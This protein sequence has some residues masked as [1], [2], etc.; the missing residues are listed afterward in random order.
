MNELQKKWLK[1][2]MTTATV[3]ADCVQSERVKLPEGSLKDKIPASS[4]G[5]NQGR[6]HEGGGIWLSLEGISEGGQGEP[7]AHEATPV[8]PAGCTVT[9][10]GEYGSYGFQPLISDP[11]G[12]ATHGERDLHPAAMQ[13]NTSYMRILEEKHRGL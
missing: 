7:Q 6:L 4:L 2:S 3:K 1:Y 5:E 13:M 9:D 11:Q 12:S 10:N 8:A